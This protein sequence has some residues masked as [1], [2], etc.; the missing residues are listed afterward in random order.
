MVRQTAACPMLNSP[1][2]PRS[3]IINRQG[4]WKATGRLASTLGS[5]AK[6]LVCI[7]TMPRIPAM[8][9]P[10]TMP[11]A[12]SSRAVLKAVEIRVGVDGVDQRLQDIVRHIGDEADLIRLQR[13]DHDFVPRLHHPCPSIAGRP[14]SAGLGFAPLGAA[15]RSPLG[16]RGSA[17][18]KR[19]PA[20][21]I[22]P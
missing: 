8:T 9:A 13:L 17:G 4:I 15:G 22:P 5:V 6:P 16:P 2:V 18:R 14:A 21:V 1:K 10:Q 7:S 11:T 19:H 20:G 12:S 3:E